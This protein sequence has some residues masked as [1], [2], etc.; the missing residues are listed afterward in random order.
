MTTSSIPAFVDAL[1][2]VFMGDKRL[3]HVIVPAHIYGKVL[4]L[5]RA[6]HQRSP[7]KRPLLVL[8]EPFF[9]AS[10]G[11]PERVQAIVA[12]DLISVSPPQAA[13]PDDMRP[14]TA[15]LERVVES[16][17][18]SAAPVVVFAPQ[19]IDDAGVF[20][21]EIDALLEH[22]GLAPVQ[23]VV[24]DAA[25]SSLGDLVVRRGNATTCLVLPDAN[26][27]QMESLHQVIDH[28][29]SCIVELPAT[30]DD[31][32]PKNSPLRG[33]GMELERQRLQD[34]A[35]MAAAGRHAEAAQLY[36][37][38]ADQLEAQNL[39]YEGV[40]VKFDCAR[41]TVAAGSMDEG[42][43]L[44]AATLMDAER[45]GMIGI[46]P[47]AYASL[48]ALHV[49]Q[50]RHRDALLAYDRAAAVATQ[51][52][53]DEFAADMHRCAGHAALNVDDANTAMNHWTRAFASL[54]KT[55]PMVAGLDEP[56]QL[57]TVAIT[58]ADIFETCGNLAAAAGLRG[59]AATIE[60]RNPRSPASWS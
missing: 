7:G 39:H 24:A 20:A 51:R 48:G 54:G 52:G 18:P 6:L 57:V 25:K 8:P 41:C 12:A 26:H 3:L 9:G 21:S 30:L 38:V 50:R 10:R 32:C 43:R 22:P 40:L 34:A 47:E 58:L 56:R 19:H 1:R 46:V 45:R 5:L 23:W 42:Q 31:L 28:L 29:T 4:A 35:A 17:G 15:L 49:R 60:R 13:S 11:W 27:R 53:S 14:F 44:F 37:S 16:L 36:M 59:H 33:T 2:S 55:P